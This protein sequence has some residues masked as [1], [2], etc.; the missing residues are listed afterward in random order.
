M[1]E[2]KKK[3]LWTAKAIGAAILNNTLSGTFEV[4]R[5]GVRVRLYDL[6]IL[7]YEIVLKLALYGL[8]KKILDKC[9]GHE[10]KGATAEM[11][12]EEM[13]KVWKQLVEN[14]WTTR[15]AAEPSTTLRGAVKNL[16]RMGLPKAEEANMIKAAFMM[17]GSA[18]VHE[19]MVEQLRDELAAEDD[20]E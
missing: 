3:H 19:K 16:L 9:A 1:T 7:P 18:T 2:D 10:K 5:E 11:Q 14:S 17:F 12:G 6:T 20:E 15:K 4:T 8:K 13:D